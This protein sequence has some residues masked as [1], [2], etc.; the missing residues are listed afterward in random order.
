MKRMEQQ[1]RRTPSPVLRIPEALLK[2]TVLFEI[3]ATHGMSAA[4]QTIPR[5]EGQNQDTD[6]PIIKAF[7][8]LLVVWIWIGTG[9]VVLG[10]KVALM[11]NG[12]MTLVASP[13][14]GAVSELS[15][16]LGSSSQ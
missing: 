14:S 15:E 9:I 13:A 4:V 1:L 7:L 5:N 2:Y 11:P 10:A 16:A 3:E 8:N 12:R 6:L